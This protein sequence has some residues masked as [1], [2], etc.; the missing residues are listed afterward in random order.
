MSLGGS[1]DSIMIWSPRFN[2]MVGAGQ[3]TKYLSS[4]ALE[5]VHA[6]Y[7]ATGTPIDA[8]ALKKSPKVHP[9]KFGVTKTDDMIDVL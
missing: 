1:G 4:A 9:K 8:H 7:K 6:R 2:R 3:Q 5:L